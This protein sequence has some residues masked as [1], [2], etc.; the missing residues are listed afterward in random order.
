MSKPHILITGASGNLG[1]HLIMALAKNNKY[2]L[3]GLD[4]R[5]N[6]KIQRSIRFVE[7]DLNNIDLL[8]KTLNGV[9]LICHCASIGTGMDDFNIITD[10]QFLTANIKGTQN[11]YHQAKEKG[12]NK[13][14]LTSSISVLSLDLRKENWPVNE[15]HVSWPDDSYGMSKKIQEII[16]RSFAD[17]GSINTLALRPCAFFPVDDPDRGF[18]LAGAHAMVE[19]IVNAHVAAVEVLLDEKKSSNLHGFEAIFITNKLP[20]QNSDK[21][22]IDPDGNMKKLISKYWPDHAKYF[23]DLGFKK[24]LFPCVYDLSKAKRILN[25]EP[26]FNFDQWLIYCKEKNLDFQDFKKQIQT[27]RSW[28]YKIKRKFFKLKKKLL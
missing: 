10:N 4:I 6:S 12:V 16:A 14:V 20:Y 8:S 25:W 22:L 9:N 27:K 17:N 15:H 21:S 26:T 7:A 5:T 19:D 3:T 18:R 24:A 2:D 23:F 13:I 1:S 28:K 11:L